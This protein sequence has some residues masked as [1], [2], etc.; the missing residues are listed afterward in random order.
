MKKQCTIFIAL[1]A[2]FVF[3]T[4]QLPAHAYTEEEKQFVKSMLSAYGYSPDMAGAYQAYADYLSGM[5]DDICEQYGLPKQGQGSKPADPTPSETEA[6][7]P[8]P[9]ETEAPSP[10]E[11]ETP[12]TDPSK[13]GTETE[14]PGDGN[15]TD[16]SESQK[17]PSGTDPS[18]NGGESEQTK[19]KNINSEE[20]IENH[21]E[22][23]QPVR[24]E[25]SYQVTLMEVYADH[26]I[27]PSMF[28]ND[29][30]EYVCEDETC[31]YIDMVFQV[32]NESTEELEVK[33]LLSLTLYD[34]ENDY[35]DDLRTLLK[36]EQENTENP[37][38]PNA[39]TAID[40]SSTESES[41]FSEAEQEN[42]DTLLFSEQA[43]GTI[44]SK[45][46]TLSPD[47]QGLFHYAVKVPAASTDLKATIYID[48]QVYSFSFR[49]DNRSHQ[50][51]E[52]QE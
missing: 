46:T 41:G 30:Q 34:G 6:P 2:S 51:Q 20:T 18:G 4:A 17:D 19:D 25:G 37:D 12:K 42:D 9:S 14:K 48:E 5:Y 24:L 49:T 43:D 23:N 39:E 36:A 27:Q 7:A 10:S 47:A 15:I 21:I 1:L 26:S 28:Q 11:G 3:G 8:S 38:N 16:P 31:L 35:G 22:L 45:E 13:E 50:T 32:A 29:D 52:N 33:D 44:L 40:L